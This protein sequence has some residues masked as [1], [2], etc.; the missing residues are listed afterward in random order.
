MPLAKP[1]QSF[2]PGSVK[3]LSGSNGVYELADEQGTVLYI[4]YAGS[5]AN[6]GLR[7]KIAGHFSEAELNPVI[8][9]RVAQFRYEVTAMY[10]SRWVD[11]LTRHLEDYETLPEGNR[12]SDE[13]IPTLGRF[14]WKSWTETGTATH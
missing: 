7:G 8:R 6:F 11:L 9:D 2:D 13:A 10:Y 3:R 5:K 1:W 12:A 4:G 14:H